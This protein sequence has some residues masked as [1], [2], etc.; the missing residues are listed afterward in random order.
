MW[1]I[2][3]CSGYFGG[4]SINPYDFLACNLAVSTEMFKVDTFSTSFS[5]FKIYASKALPIGAQ[6]LKYFPCGFV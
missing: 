3:G 4:T 1:E 5:P 6:R 2:N